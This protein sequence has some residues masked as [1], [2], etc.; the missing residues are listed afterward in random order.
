MRGRSLSRQVRDFQI[1]QISVEF[2]S[3]TNLIFL[4]NH[5]K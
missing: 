1:Q 5:S 4:D 3:Q 2:E